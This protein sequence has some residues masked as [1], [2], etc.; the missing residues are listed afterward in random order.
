MTTRDGWSETL[1]AS[2]TGAVRQVHQ[3]ALGP[4]PKPSALC[5]CVF[6]LR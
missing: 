3:V 5:P 6:R 2:A 1:A 4:W